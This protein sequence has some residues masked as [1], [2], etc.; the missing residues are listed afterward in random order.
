MAVLLLLPPL[1][2]LL[3]APA[4]A[5]CLLLVP[6]CRAAPALPAALCPVSSS[7]SAP[8]SNAQHPK[9]AANLKSRAQL[10]LL[11]RKY[12]YKKLDRKRISAVTSLSSPVLVVDP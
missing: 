5:F 11:Q 12:D 6:P 3:T 4:A 9:A 7:S 10:A 1:L 8:A 2:P